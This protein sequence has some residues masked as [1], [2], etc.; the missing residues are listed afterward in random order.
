MCLRSHRGFSGA[1]NY[2]ENHLKQLAELFQKIEALLVNNKINPGNVDYLSKADFPLSPYVIFRQAY[3][4]SADKSVENYIQAEDEE[5]IPQL[6]IECK[7]S[8]PY[9]VIRMHML[10]KNFSKQVD[11]LVNV[12]EN[13]EQKLIQIKNGLLLKY[14]DND[15]KVRI[16]SEK[17]NEIQRQIVVTKINNAQLIDAEY[18]DYQVAKK[19]LNKEI[20]SLTESMIKMTEF[21]DEDKNLLFA[22]RETDATK[23]KIMGVFK[24]R[25]DTQNYIETLTQDTHDRLINSTRKKL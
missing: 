14:A 13:Y 17:L 23:L 19:E 16:V 10:I 20:K 24:V 5:K 4:N 25:P 8:V 22:H 11:E 9:Q 7:N 12:L 2:D 15:I 21:D 3:F 1:T 6:I 18:K